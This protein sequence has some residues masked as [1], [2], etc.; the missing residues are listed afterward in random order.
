MNLL[1]EMWEGRVVKAV[2][3]DNGV[4]MVTHKHGADMSGDLGLGVSKLYAIFH[5]DDVYNDSGAK[6][7]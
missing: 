6:L 5:L 4:I 3:N 1:P 7:R 2:D